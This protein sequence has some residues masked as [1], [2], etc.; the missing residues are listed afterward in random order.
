MPT[1]TLPTSGADQGRQLQRTSRT[2]REL[3]CA[4]NQSHEVVFMVDS[5][6]LLGYVNPAFER[7]TGYSA[8]EALGKNLSSIAGGTTKAGGLQAH[9]RAS[10]TARNLSWSS[11]GLR[12]G[13]ENIRA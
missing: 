9:T 1:S 4:V 2:L 12:Q 13:R 5:A 8:Q 7:L 10:L 6:G 11:G 3:R